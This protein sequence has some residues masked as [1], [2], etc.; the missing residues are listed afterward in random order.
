MT[1][2]THILSQFKGGK[3]NVKKPDAVFISI[4]SR[5]ESWSGYNQ[6]VIKVTLIEAED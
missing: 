5:S 1:H 4:I 3:L 6:K 2:I